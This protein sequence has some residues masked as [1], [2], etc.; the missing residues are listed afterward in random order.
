MA[1]ESDINDVATLD[2]EQGTG[3]GLE[4]ERADPNEEIEHPFDPEK[5]AIDTVPRVIQQIITRIEHDEI[6]LE[7]DFQRLRNIWTFKQKSRLIESLLLRIPLPAFYVAADASDNW[8]V[9]DGIQRI[10]TIY[11]YV[12]GEFAL[13]NLE[14]LLNLTGKKFNDLSRPMQR[15]IGETSLV[16][17]I[18]KPGTPEEVMFNIFSR[19]NTGGM[20]LNNQEIRHALHK[21]LARD[22]LRELAETE[23]FLTATDN[24]V[25][26]K[27]MN[28]RECVLRFLAFYIETWKKY[29]AGDLDSH[30][31]QTMNKVNNMSDAER[32]STMEDFKKAMR[33]A[34]AIFGTYAFRKQY[35]SA[36]PRNPINK[37]LFETWSVHLARCS[38]G[39][40]E[41][42]TANR[43][44]LSSA[45]IE[46]INDDLLFD[47]AISYSTSHRRHIMK[48]FSAI[49]ELIKRFSQ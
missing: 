24:T 33:A 17:N 5:I 18:I 2:D 21:G 42:L 7:P 11:D 40:I 22:Y 1:D 48:R 30:L 35:Q 49:G 10:S 13:S 26:T 12:R 45:F 32:H 36:S 44:S 37:A 4:P 8:N 27:R 31:R 28:D 41:T 29:D 20:A 47:D 34:T 14:Y 6:N 43:D 9:V 15:R 38:D 39:E 19:I 3:L 23:E 16:I 46:L 25:N